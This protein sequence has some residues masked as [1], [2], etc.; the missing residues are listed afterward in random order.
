MFEKVVVIDGRGHLMGR[1]AS[2]VAKELLSGQKVVVVRCEELLMSGSLM[3]NKMTYHRYL[4]KRVN[5]NPSRG[6]YH[7]RAPGR[8][9]FRVVRGMVPHKSARGGLALERLK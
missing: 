1:L 7:F 5:T 3:R 9:F 2:I 4:R 6:P 8:M